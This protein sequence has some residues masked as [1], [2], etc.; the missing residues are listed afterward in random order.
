MIFKRK[1]AVFKIIFDELV[2]I[3]KIINEEKDWTKRAMARDKD[4]E[5]LN[6]PQDPRAVSWCILGACNKI[7]ASPD[8]Y[9]YLNYLANELG[10]SD[11]SR[12]NDLVTWEQFTR[13][14]LYAIETA[15]KP[16]IIK[17]KK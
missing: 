11:I 3:S 17:G 10:Y 12:F 8:V 2:T 9:S 6:D 14:Y 13:F 7:N 4:G 15:S 5:Q 1:I 16:T